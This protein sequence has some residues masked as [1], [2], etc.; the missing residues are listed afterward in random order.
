MHVRPHAQKAYHVLKEGYAI[1]DNPAN[2]SELPDG[3]VMT[4]QSF[5]FNNSYIRQMLEAA[6]DEE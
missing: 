5:W 6:L 2:G 3:R 4:K 1:G